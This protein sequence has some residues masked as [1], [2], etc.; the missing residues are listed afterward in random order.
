MW[1]VLTFRI[2]TPNK[3]H[4]MYCDCNDIYRIVHCPMHNWKPVHSSRALHTQCQWA[5]L[6]RN[7]HNFIWIVA[8]INCSLSLLLLPS[9]ILS[10]AYCYD[11]QNIR[12]ISLC[13]CSSASFSLSP[14]LLHPFPCSP[15]FDF[16]LIKLSAS[17]YGF[18]SHYGSVLS[19]F[20]SPPFFSV[21]FSLFFNVF[22][23]LPLPLCGLAHTTFPLSTAPRQK[24]SVLVSLEST[25]ICCFAFVMA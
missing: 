20:G 16:S 5:S 23:L 6:G 13:D 9:F 2:N 10:L 3:R 4:Q 12:F 11:I 25:F 18:L 19:R 24:G 1:I 15:A 8:L 14:L 17:G 22:L 7:L 21:L